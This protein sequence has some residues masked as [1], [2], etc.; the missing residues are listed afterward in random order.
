LEELIND[1]IVRWGASAVQGIESTLEIDET[2]INAAANIAENVDDR[3][4]IISGFIQRYGIW[5]GPWKTLPE[6]QNG[7]FAS[8]SAG[9]ALSYFDELE[10]VGA[11]WR[12][13]FC[14]LNRVIR[15]EYAGLGG[16][17]ERSFCSWT[18]KVLWLRFPE[19]VPI[20]DSKA[21]KALTVMS[22]TLLPSQPVVNSLDG[23]NGHH[24]DCD[25]YSAY[26]ARHSAMF[27]LFES[28]ISA[29]LQ[30]NN[31]STDQYQKF[32]F[33]DKLLWCLGG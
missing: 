1:I 19:H 21:L 16:K 29:W 13:H 17:S 2:G 11:G 26:C 6:V 8:W 28:S 22:N 3:I 32:R 5:Q 7:T 31:Q 23:H 4:D 25:K 12:S 9:V 20:Y 15:Q 14:G 27:E 33:F 30:E 10:D 18:S 24:N